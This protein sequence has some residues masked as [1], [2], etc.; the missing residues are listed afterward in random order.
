[1]P[2]DYRNFQQKSRRYKS[3]KGH[4]KQSNYHT[5]GKQSIRQKNK[6]TILRNYKRSH[7]RNY[8]YNKIQKQSKYLH[9]INCTYDYQHRIKWH[10]YNTWHRNLFITNV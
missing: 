4:H 5:K 7:Q 3:G 10:Y 2:F 1:M 8:N 9:D 6:Y